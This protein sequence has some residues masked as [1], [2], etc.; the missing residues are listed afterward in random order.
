LLFHLIS[1]LYERA[2]LAIASRNVNEI[3]NPKNR[4]NQALA[5]EELSTGRRACLGELWGLAD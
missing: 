5:A 1:K 3:E 2:S 4:E